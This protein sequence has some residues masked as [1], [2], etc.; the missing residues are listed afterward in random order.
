M[1]GIVAQ[2]KAQ[3]ERMR[4]PES[5]L[6]IGIRTGPVTSGVVGRRKEPRGAVE[7][8]HRRQFD[9]FFLNRLRPDLSRDPEGRQPNDKF[10]AE[11]KRLLTGLSG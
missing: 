10:A 5:E 6:R 2:M 7:V 8:K 11:C 9:M 4:L 3:R 1:Q